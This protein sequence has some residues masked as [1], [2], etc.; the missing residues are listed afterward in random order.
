MAFPTSEHSKFSTEKQAERSWKK[1][2]KYYLK[3]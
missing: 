1:R 3:E 2:G